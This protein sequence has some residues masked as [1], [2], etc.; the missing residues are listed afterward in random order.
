MEIDIIF[1]PWVQILRTGAY[2]QDTIDTALKAEGLPNLAWYDVLL[3]LMRVHPAPLR[4]FELADKLL[5]KQY[6]L[7]RQ[8]SRMVEAGVL[9]KL[10]AEND[11]RGFS[12]VITEKGLAQRQEMWRVYSF[13]LHQAIGSKLTLNEAEGL[14]ATL[15]KL[16][17]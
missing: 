9:E 10:P 11:G 15:K 2:L 12:L 8:I 13:V 6:N 7:S 5:L 1:D 3:E 17:P 14:V 16:R 4:P